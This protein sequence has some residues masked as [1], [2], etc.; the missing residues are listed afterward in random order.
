MEMTEST[1]RFTFMAACGLG[2]FAAVASITLGVNEVRGGAALFL[3]FAL[4]AAVL[5][6]ISYRRYTALRSARW[7]TE[8]KSSEDALNQVLNHTRMNVIIDHVTGPLDS[9][10]VRPESDVSEDSPAS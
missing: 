1:A 5:T 6:F 3:F 2:L 8:L 4:V 9:K 10:T 7:R